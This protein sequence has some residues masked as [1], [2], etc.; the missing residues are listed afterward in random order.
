MKNI[1]NVIWVVFWL[2]VFIF[3]PFSVLGFIGMAIFFIHILEI[4]IFWKRIKNNPIEGI[5]MTFV[6]GYV[7]LRGLRK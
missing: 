3:D 5:V 6:F 7:Y 4:V 2:A 1:L